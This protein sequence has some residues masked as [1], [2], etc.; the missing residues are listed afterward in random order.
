MVNGP[1]FTRCRAC[2]SVSQVSNDPS[3]SVKVNMCARVELLRTQERLDAVGRARERVNSSAEPE[4]RW[5]RR[6]RHVLQAASCDATT[7]PRGAAEGA[8][9]AF[10]E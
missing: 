8:K 9:R 7:G 4:I 3:R 1:L 10:L 2:D 6:G 5:E